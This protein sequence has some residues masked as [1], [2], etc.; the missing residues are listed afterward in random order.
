[1]MATTHAYMALGLVVLSLPVSGRHAPEASLMVAA[2]LGGLAPDADLVT[3]H[4]KTLHFPVLLPV[5]ALL[6][7]AV[8]RVV[9]SPA[10]VVLAVAVASAGLHSL[11]DILA[12]GVGYE[13]WEHTS[14]RAVYNHVL[15]VWHTPRRLVRYS[16]APEDFALGAV[17]ALP[18]VFAPQTGP[19]ADAVLAATLLA[20]G[21]YT[22]VRRRLPAIA[23]RFRAVAPPRLADR[24]PAVGFEER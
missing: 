5:G 16:G 21:L 10:V 2:S 4:R 13:P 17:A 6:L 1:M 20:T 7:L 3:N 14:D 19:V 23:G 24:L 8:Y 18:A 11:T 12:G 22:L 15:G 9:G